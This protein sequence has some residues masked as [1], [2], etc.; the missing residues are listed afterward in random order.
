MQSLATHVPLRPN[1]RL[2]FADTL[3]L[4]VPEVAF[5]P[6]VFPLDAAPFIRRNPAT[7]AVECIAATFGLLPFW[8]RDR[9][10]GRKTYN[11]RSECGSDILG[12]RR[13][14]PSTS[15]AGRP[16]RRC[17]GGSRH[18]PRRAWEPLRVQDR[19]ELTRLIEYS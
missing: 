14:P 16:A 17:V 5:K 1:Q 9:S 13:W 10:I 7:G 8:S 18:L 4:T 6:S 19:T 15:R 11:A 3:R 2:L 12:S